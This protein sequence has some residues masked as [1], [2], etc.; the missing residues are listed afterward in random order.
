MGFFVYIFFK[1]GNR[2]KH[3]DFVKE[4]GRTY[5]LK[6]NFLS[7]TCVNHCVRTFQ[8]VKIAQWHR[9]TDPCAAIQSSTKFMQK[10]TL[11]YLFPED[12]KVLLGLSWRF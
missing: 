9:F 3:N 8:R 7:L 5:F 6:G 4:K 11:G 12:R 10:C 2:I 1:A